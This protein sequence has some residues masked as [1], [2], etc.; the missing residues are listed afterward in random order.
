MEGL[1]GNTVA[2]AG[3]I[4]MRRPGDDVDRNLYSGEGGNILFA[5]NPLIEISSKRL[6]SMIKSGK[7]VRYLVPD[8]VR[9]YIKDKELYWN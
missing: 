8:E 1:P 9:E 7:S 3:I 5:A 2:S 4:V 6:R